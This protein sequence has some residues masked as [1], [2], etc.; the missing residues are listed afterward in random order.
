[1]RTAFI[2]LLAACATASCSSKPTCEKTVAHMRAVMTAAVVDPG[3]DWEKSY[4][5][6][7]RAGWSEEHMRC[8]LSYDTTKDITRN[9]NE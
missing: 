2:L 1:M 7:C 9:C 4:L 6:K 8:I 5:E 3:E